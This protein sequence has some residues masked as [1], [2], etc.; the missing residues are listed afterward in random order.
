MCFALA[1]LC[2]ITYGASKASAEKLWLSLKIYGI[3]LLCFI[4]VFIML[5]AFSE[6]SIKD[7]SSPTSIISDITIISIVIITLIMYLLKRKQNLRSANN[8]SETDV[9]RYKKRLKIIMIPA[10]V[11]PIAVF[12]F[13]LSYESIRNNYLLFSFLIAVICIYLFLL[14]FLMKNLKSD[15]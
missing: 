13:L 6:F 9:S 3:L 7:M 12:V 14:V 11:V 1:V 2:M 8:C 5:P 15:S 10:C 4:P